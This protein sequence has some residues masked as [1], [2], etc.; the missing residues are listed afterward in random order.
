[1]LFV[2]FLLFLYLFR[3]FDSLILLFFTELNLWVFLLFC[4]SSSRFFS[5]FFFLYL[6]II[7]IHFMFLFLL[8]SYFIFAFAS[9]FSLFLIFCFYSFIKQWFPKILSLC[10][11]NNLYCFICQWCFFDLHIKG[12]YPFTLPHFYIVGF[13]SLFPYLWN[14][15]LCPSVQFDFCYI[16]NHISTIF[17]DICFLP[18]FHLS[19]V[20]Y[21]TVLIDLFLYYFLQLLAVS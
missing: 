21:S 10:C 19:V 14:Y 13:W 6:F 9:F 15:I 20:Q 8:L 7:L 11:S 16:F 5:F 12:H 1:M 17:N 2:F 4:L 18:H 3:Y